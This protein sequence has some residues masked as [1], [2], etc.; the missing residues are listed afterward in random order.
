MSESFVPLIPP[1]APGKSQANTN[2]RVN[3][4]PNTQAASDPVPPSNVEAVAHSHASDQSSA[5]PVVT[6][7]RDG[8]R[9][10]GIRIV[11]TCG[12]TIDLSCVY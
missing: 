1:K 4:I 3:V 2:F 6:V 9:V 11:C 5:Q 12:Q 7:Q 8:D 10:T